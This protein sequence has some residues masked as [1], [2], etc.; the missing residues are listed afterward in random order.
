M[1][2]YRG[3]QS[4]KDNA[5]AHVQYRDRGDKFR[6][7][8]Q[9]PN[10]SAGVL[11]GLSTYRDGKLYKILRESRISHTNNKD[12]YFIPF[13]KLEL[14]RN[15]GLVEQALR[16]GEASRDEI[17]KWVAKIC[18]N[19]PEGS[20]SFFF[21]TFAILVLCENARCIGRF[22]DRNIDDS[23]LPLPT[24]ERN[25]NGIAILRKNNG[26]EIS[27]ETLKYLFQD[28]REW[29]QGNLDNFA[30]YQWWAIAPFFYRPDNIIP[31]YVLEA[32]DVL[33]FTEK[34]NHLEV[35]VESLDAE[36]KQ[37]V[38]QGGFGDVFIVKVHPSHYYFRN[39]PYSDNSHSFA[40][41]RLKSLND[42]DFQLEVD[43]LSKYNY[44]IDKHLIPLLATIE[45]ESEAGK[46]Y[47]LFPKAN[48]D[49]RFFWKTQFNKNPN[50][51]STEVRWMAEQCLGIANALSTLHKDQDA[52][53]G[54]DYPIYGRHGDIKAGNIL[55]FSKPGTSD[56]SGWCLV[57]SDFGLMR[58]HR[59]ISISAQTANKLKKTLT[60]QA[61]EFDIAGAKISRKSDIWALGCTYLEFITCYLSGYEAVEEEFPS[62]RGEEDR[63]LP[64]VSEDKF[65]RTTADG[66]SA[67]L[68]PGVQ[69]WISDLRSNPKCTQY[70]QEFL[71]L[72]EK[73]ML[74]IERERRLPAADVAKN[75]ES[76]L[77]KCQRESYIIEKHAPRVTRRQ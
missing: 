44:G 32:S 6:R 40:L 37:A 4:P 46:Y 10:A 54:D 77:K 35:E 70:F 2:Q 7:E 3:G 69:N 60:Y 33:P 42:K 57:L 59:A 21:R 75:L 45:K 13:D 38:L 30:T 55:W 66:K 12:T 15:P 34:K 18:T 52:G 11:N 1:T 47:L 41:K 20:E 31:H 65:Y 5:N 48:G 50:R 19:Q 26:R 29:K 43:A 17:S 64:G 68:K 24:V 61:P 74:R 56:P 9:K 51:V 14:A 8:Y 53:N 23:Y 22:I 28:R 36:V 63:N 76:L 71:D 73:G 58:F 49:L 27:E 62:C 72:I 67:E 16:E 25:E 39:Q